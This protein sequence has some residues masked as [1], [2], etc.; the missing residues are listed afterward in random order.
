M[1]NL[2]YHEDNQVRKDIAFNDIAAWT[3]KYLDGAI[4]ETELSHKVIEILTIAGIK[5]D[6]RE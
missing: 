5:W 3:Q 2:P 4:T 1:P 6:K